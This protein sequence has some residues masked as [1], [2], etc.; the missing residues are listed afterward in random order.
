MNPITSHHRRVQLLCGVLLIVFGLLFLFDRLD[1]HDLTRIWL[2]WPV[3]ML[4]FAFNKMVPPTTSKLF[5]SGLWEACFAAA[6][7]L[8]IE[9]FFDVTL[10]NGWTF[11]ALWGVTIFNSWPFLLIAAGACMV[12]E[13]LLE[14]YL[15]RHRE[16]QHEKP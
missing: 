12:I 11:E 1:W 2:Y 13:P 10:W 4:V 8:L 3:L 14:R 7:Y 6:C 16:L 15:A 9:Q 5:V